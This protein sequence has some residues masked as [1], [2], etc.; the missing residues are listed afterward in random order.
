MGTRVKI[1]REL[2]HMSNIPPISDPNTPPSPVPAG[3]PHKPKL[4]AEAREWLGIAPADLLI[5]AAMLGAFSLF[6]VVNIPL[7]LLISLVAV[8]L[9]LY[10]CVVGLKPNP[11]FSR[12]TNVM[13]LAGYPAGMFVVV[14]FIALNFLSWN[15]NPQAGF[16]PRWR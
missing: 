6:Y 10:A 13:K 16:F 3:E 5:Y 15:P 2:K 14:L 8:V 7:E 12:L 1:L 4:S 11:Q 9:G